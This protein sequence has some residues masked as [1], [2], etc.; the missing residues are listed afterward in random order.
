MVE[1][2]AFQSYTVSRANNNRRWRSD[3]PTRYFLYAG[4]DQNPKHCRQNDKSEG[5]TPFVKEHGG[6]LNGRLLFLKIDRMWGVISSARRNEEDRVSRGCSGEE[7]ESHKCGVSCEVDRECAR[8][9]EV[10]Q[11]GG[12]EDN[13]AL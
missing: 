6:R 10:G 5:G 8:Q 4:T 7:R 13:R 1:W 12:R 9:Q 3:L 11:A 2:E